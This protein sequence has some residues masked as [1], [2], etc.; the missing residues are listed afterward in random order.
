[1]LNTNITTFRKNVFSM[2]EQTVRYNETLNIS[3]KDGNAIIIS[4]D[5]YRSLTETVGLLSIPG[6]RDKL[7]RGRAEPLADCVSESEVE[8]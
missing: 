1:M 7:L 4:E 5:D 3:T 6:M 2:L 8:W